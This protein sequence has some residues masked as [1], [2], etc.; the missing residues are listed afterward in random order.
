MSK[1]QCFVYWKVF[2]TYFKA[3]SSE[4]LG[5]SPRTGKPV[6]GTEITPIREHALYCDSRPNIEDFETIGTQRDGNNHLLEL[7]ES[8]FIYR[9]APILNKDTTSRPLHLFV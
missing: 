7:K 6:R 5:I 8:I 1:L 9:H 2:Q 4:H 3:R